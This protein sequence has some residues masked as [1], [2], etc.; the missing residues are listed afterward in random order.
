MGKAVADHIE[1]TEGTEGTETGKKEGH[2][3]VDRLLCD[4][5]ILCALS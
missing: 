3:E 2:Q 1:S 4:L 5:C